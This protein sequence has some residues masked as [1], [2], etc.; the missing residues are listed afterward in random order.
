MTDGGGSFAVLRR[1]EAVLRGRTSAR[2]VWLVLVCGP[3]YGAVMGAYD[4]SPLQS[5]YSAVKLPLLLAATAGLSLP[6]FF[7]VNTLLGLRA[8]FPQALRALVAAQAGLTVIL[9]SLAPLT[10]FWYVSTTD[11]HTS[12]LFNGVMFGVASLGAQVL[13][14][15]GYRPLLEA[16]PKHLW[17]LRAWLVVYSF[18]GVQM[19]WVLR[20]FV[21]NP[22]MP[23]SFFRPGAWEN[24]YVIVAKMA[25][26]AL[27]GPP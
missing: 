2:D 16:D 22:A 5:V 12:I 18:V 27:A 9:V 4:G 15:R 19:G 17:V 24:A 20:P 1:A 3:A 23:V 11:Y 21:G 10:A 13:L 8:D 7:I 6:S 25:W 14:N 26:E